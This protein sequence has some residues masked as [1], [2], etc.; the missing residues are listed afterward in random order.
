M[1]L[2][3]VLAGLLLPPYARTLFAR[4]LD[5]LRDDEGLRLRLRLADELA[6]FPWEF[7]YIQD[8]RGE[9]T[10]SS[11][12]ALDPRI[13]IVRHEAL[14][15]PGDHFQ[16][17]ESRRVVIAMA[18]PEPHSR[19]PQLRN[20]PSERAALEGALQGVPGIEAVF[21]PEGDMGSGGAEGFRG[22]TLADVASALMERTD[23]FHFSGHGEFSQEPGPAFGGAVGEGGLVFADRENRAVPVAADRFAE[24]LT[25]RGVRLVVLGACDSGRRDGHNLWSG[26][27]AA[28]L[29]AGVPAVVA[30]QFT[31]NDRL[32]AAFDTTF[33]QGLVAGLTI[34]EAVALGRAAVR[35][36][37]LESKPDVRDWAAPVLYLRSPG[38]RVFKPVEDEDARESAQQAS[39]HL[40]E[41][42][43]QSVPAAGRVIGPV[44][45]E[46]REGVVTVDQ[47][48]EARASGLVVGAYVVRVQAGKLVVRQKADV[49]D[50]TMIAAVIDQVGGPASGEGAAGDALKRLEALLRMEAVGDSG[51]ADPPT[52]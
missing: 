31:I 20:L 22:A 32:A 50:G 8:A 9:R 46:L 2:G 35:R 34:D 16:A 4:S 21:L 37:A 23:V 45:A 49:V 15:V 18:S 51:G 1:D 13:S 12:L 14:A 3:E 44:V 11:F 47:S 38:G 30:M 19:Y 6:D 36:K 40:F 24:M 42:H 41:Q 7:A 48:I 5:R 28:L 17:P 43:V 33:Y 39:E 10:P 26:V 25:G 27:A 29:K 52:G